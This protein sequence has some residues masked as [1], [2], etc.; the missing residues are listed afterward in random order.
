MESAKEWEAEWPE[1]WVWHQA[2]HLMAV[3]EVFDEGLKAII[4]CRHWARDE[5]EVREKKAERVGA[6]AN[7]VDRS[8]E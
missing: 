2:L 7:G 8:G 6:R 1:L 3:T 5:R 4:A